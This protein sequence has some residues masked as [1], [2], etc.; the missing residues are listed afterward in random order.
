MR[1]CSRPRIVPMSEPVCVYVTWSPSQAELLAGALRSL[2]FTA[3][4]LSSSA[5]GENVA[6]A[7]IMVPSADEAEARQAIAELEAN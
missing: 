7:R 3:H 4:V 1:F 6:S 2:G 5:A